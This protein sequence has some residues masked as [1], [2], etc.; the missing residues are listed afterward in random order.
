MRCHSFVLTSALAV[1]ALFSSAGAG[2][3]MLYNN[4]NLETCA[5]TN[6]AVMHQNHAWSMDAF[7]IWYNWAPGEEWVNYELYLNL[8]RVTSGRLLRGS[9]DPYQ[10]S[11]C[12]ARG[13][14]ALSAGDYSTLEV[15]TE[16][17]HVC[18]NDRAA[19]GFI[20][21]YGIRPPQ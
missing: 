3:P 6:S 10:K 2:Y 13:E 8:K 9:C 14:A 12:V 16:Y 1:T 21:V 17:A 20:H 11:W 18:K 4:W 15:R 7:E 19:E 5:T